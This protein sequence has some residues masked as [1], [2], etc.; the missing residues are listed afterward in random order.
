MTDRNGVN[1]D[2][3]DMDGNTFDSELYLQKILKVIHT[4]DTPAI[5]KWF[6][7]TKFCK[8]YHRIVH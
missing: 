5:S 8:S 3:L 7:S 1:V 6:H 2:A 4:A